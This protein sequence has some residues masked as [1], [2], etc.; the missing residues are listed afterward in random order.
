MITAGGFQT[1]ASGAGQ[2]KQRTLAA[3]ALGAV[4]AV[5]AAFTSNS[6]FQRF[7]NKTNLLTLPDGQSAVKVTATFGG[8]AGDI[9][10]IQVIV[11]GTDVDDQALVESLPAATVNTAGSVT[12]VGE[13]KTITQIEIPAHDGTGATTSIGISGYGAADV[14]AAF[15]DVGVN[16]IFKTATITNPAVPR[17]LTAT[18]GGTAG[19]IKA[20]TPTVRGTNEA[21][22]AIAE[23][24]PAFTVDT[25]GSIVG[26]K[27][28]KTVTEIDLPAHDG[29][30]ATTSFG[31]GAKLGVGQILARNSALMAFLNNVREATMPTVVTDADEIEKN[32]FSLN[33]AL[34]GS[35]V[36]LYYLDDRG[37]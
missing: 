19:D 15:T 9:K 18:A 22:V 23:T 30:G 26:S 16:A 36:V 24:L 10:A 32:T 25:A 4:A 3:V 27:A 14:L 20:I 33:S 1:S 28:F 13:F 35:T 37:D 21:G 17:N 8:T 5:M 6:K 31:T 29:T 7:F 11:T 2:V 34:D 12:S